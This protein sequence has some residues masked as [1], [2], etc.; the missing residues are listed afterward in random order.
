V[1]EAVGENDSSSPE[2]D[3][4]GKEERIL[5]GGIAA[6]LLALFLWVYLDPPDRRAVVEGCQA[7]DPA[8]CFVTISADP[9]A[10]VAALLAV[11]ALLFLI[12]LLGRR[13]STVKLPGGTELSRA[14]ASEVPD[15]T[16]NKEMA[17]GRLVRLATTGS[18]GADADLWT[19]L[20]AWAQSALYTW[21]AENP[22]LRIPVTD[23]ITSTHKPSGQGNHPWY[24]QLDDGQ[25]TARTLRV[26]VGRGSPQ[27]QETER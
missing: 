13:F 15:D 7:E 9:G 5:A 26:S 21:A 6:A 1:S 25:G 11:S 19:E 14:E 16:P 27:A 24:V 18:A 20:P 3:M 22:V 2:P 17:A 10:E 8:T 23:A 12:A 4:L